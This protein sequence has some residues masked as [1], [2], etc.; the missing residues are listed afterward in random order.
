M[1][2][3]LASFAS[4]A[5]GFLVVTGCGPAKLTVTKSYEVNLGEAQAIEL[6]PQPK[7]QKLTVN[8]NATEEVNVLVFKAA[9]ASGDAMITADAKKALTSKKGKTETF[10]VD[11][12]EKTA[13]AIV[14]REPAKK[15][16]VELTVTNQK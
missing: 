14:V 16:R 5:I 6:D 12:P 15:A 7:P 9:D 4:L 13:V 1:S 3:R 8:F 2:V 11:V 10:T